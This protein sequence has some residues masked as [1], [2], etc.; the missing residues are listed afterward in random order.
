MDDPIA[1]SLDELA[2]TLRQRPACGDWVA[3]F[4]D[5]DAIG[6]DEAAFIEGCSAQTIRRRAAEAS[7][8]GKPIGVWFASAVWLISKRRLLDDIEKRK[9]RPGLLAAMSRAEKYAEMRARQQTA[10]PDVAAATG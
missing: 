3:A 8:I 9:G 5:G 7:A 4:F 2:A 1:R 10:A 6:T